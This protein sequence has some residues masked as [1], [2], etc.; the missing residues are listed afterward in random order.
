MMAEKKKGAPVTINWALMDESWKAGIKSI[1]AIANEYQEATGR[2]V[3]PAGIKKHYDDLGIPRDL[4]GKIKAKV[5]LNKGDSDPFDSS[6]FV[7]VIYLDDSASERYFKIG[8]A[9]SFTSRFS[10]H[11]CASPFDICVACV[12]FVENMRLEEKSLHSLFKDNRIKG[13]WFK[14]SEEDLRVISSRAL[15]I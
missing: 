13:E 10:H 12:Y 14:L 3:S 4:S 6:G 1:Q 15:L 11:Q 9:S 5:I 8:M 2:K 7:Y